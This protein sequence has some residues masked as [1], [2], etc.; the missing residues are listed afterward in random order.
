MSLLLV[1]ELTDQYITITLGQAAVFLI[2]LHTARYQ[3]PVDRAVLAHYLRMA[4][5]LLEDTDLSETK[6][7]TYVA[8]VCRD[9]CRV[10]NVDVPPREGMMEE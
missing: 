7:S 9:L 6:N 10:G 2:R 5:E 1:I 4:I 8:K 3:I